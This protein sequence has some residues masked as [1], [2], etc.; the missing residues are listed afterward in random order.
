MARVYIEHDGQVF[1]AIE[2]QARTINWGKTFFGD[3]WK[4]EVYDVHKH[5]TQYPLRL[6][7]PAWSD[8]VNEDINRM[9][10]DLKERADPETI[11]VLLI[12]EKMKTGQGASQDPTKPSSYHWG[13]AVWGNGPTEAILTQYEVPS[14]FE[15]VDFPVED[16]GGGRPQQGGGSRPRPSS[17][18]PAPA[19]SQPQSQPRGNRPPASKPK[20]EGRRPPP[21]G[22]ISDGPQWGMC[23]KHAMETGQSIFTDFDNQT[24]D[25][26]GYR[27]FVLRLASM[28]W[29]ISQAGPMALED[30]HRDIYEEERGDNAEA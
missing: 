21:S 24:M 15:Y 28:N 29:H 16:D 7:L 4:L 13:V 3:G 22:N 17:N 23:L 20:E 8:D 2:I 18:R 6:E 12:R 10:R 5:I 9:D 26:P 19:R 27:V 14:D 1:A 25:W 11:E 30:L